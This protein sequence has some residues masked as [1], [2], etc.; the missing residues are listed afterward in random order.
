MRMSQS[1]LQARRVPY[2]RLTILRTFPS[3]PSVQELTQRRKNKHRSRP[4]TKR[5]STRLYASFNQLQYLY[6]AQRKRAVPPLVNLGL[7]LRFPSKQ[8]NHSED[9]HSYMDAITSQ[10]AVGD[11]AGSTL[12][13]RVHSLIRL[14]NNQTLQS[15]GS[16]SDKAK[17]ALSAFCSSGSYF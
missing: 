4:T 1:S 6:I 13:H 3:L 2:R 12:R 7:D 11:C 10:K 17:L 15:K 14:T 9:A 8:L 5:I 16:V